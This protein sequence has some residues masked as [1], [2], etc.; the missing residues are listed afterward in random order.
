LINVKGTL[1]GTTELGTPSDNG[2]VY[3]ISTTGVFKVVYTFT[4]S[5]DGSS[6][7]AGLIKVNG[8]LYSTTTRGG[9]CFGTFG[10]GTVYQIS[11]SGAERVLH[12]FSYGSDGALPFAGLIN[13]N[14][15][16][17]GTTYYGGISDNGTVYSI[18]TGGVEK[19]LYSFA[20]GSDGANPAAALID[21]NGKLYGTTTQG[22]GMGCG[23]SGCGTVFALTP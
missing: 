1:Y 8:K 14:G 22:G 12:S 16:L 2:T 18:S 15:T 4:G 21:V 6:P 9:R 11:T 7:Y 17:Y 5:P 19:V 20:G 23:G 13:V 10:C 3:R